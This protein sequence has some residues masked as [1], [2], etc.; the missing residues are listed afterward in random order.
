MPRCQAAL[1]QV[2][3]DDARQVR[4]VVVR[5]LALVRAGRLAGL[6][7]LT[8]FLPALVRVALRRPADV[9]VRWERFV[10]ELVLVRVVR[11]LVMI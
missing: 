9:P 7:A 2:R 5:T 3:V 8:R 11:F 1:R 10:R 4:A 6:R